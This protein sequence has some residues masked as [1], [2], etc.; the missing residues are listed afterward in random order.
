VERCQQKS[1]AEMQLS[2]RVKDFVREGQIPQVVML[3]TQV[4]QNNNIFEKKTIKGALKVLST[5]IDW[6]E[7]PLFDSCMI[8]I[9]DFLR[10][11]HLRSGAFQCLAALVGKGMG[12][13]EK[14]NV[15]NQSGYLEEVRDA[16]MVLIRDY[17]YENDMDDYDEEKMYMQAVSTSISHLGK[18]CLSLQTNK[19]GKDPFTDP[20]SR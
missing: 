9:R 13:I 4:L 2:S 16:Q 19:D 5:L 20:N 6:N 14:L 15:I 11:K 8:K 17:S 3:L 7:I 12:E 1:V 10:E 18:W